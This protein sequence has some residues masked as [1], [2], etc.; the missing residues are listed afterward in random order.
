MW[1]V[2]A[3]MAVRCRP[4]HQGNAGQVSARQIDTF[5]DKQFLFHND[6]IMIFSALSRKYVGVEK[7]LKLFYSF[8]NTSISSRNN[9]FAVSTGLFLKTCFIPS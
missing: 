6:W 8:F 1:N 9:S 5:C 2:A 7:T 4:M 3:E